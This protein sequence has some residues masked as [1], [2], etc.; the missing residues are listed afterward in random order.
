MR[1]TFRGKKSK[2]TN[3]KEFRSNEKI[4]SPKVIVI[5]E[6]GEK[7]GEMETQQGIL[8]AREAE[9]DL[10]EVSPKNQPPICKI[11]DF[12]SFKYQK[13]KQ[14]KK[15]KS[16]QKSTEIK[17]IKVSPRINEHDAGLRIAQAVKFLNQGDKVKVETQLRGRENKYPDLAGKIIK[18][19]V[20]QISREFEKEIK[21]EQELK[22]QG[23]RLSMIIFAQ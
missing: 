3:Q 13:E 20:E 18:N 16:K 8:K 21:V 12:G 22:K 2:K 5:G 4:I 15:Q 1:K 17:T 9:L 6:N 10:V 7:L 19:I 14:E 23:N 11:M